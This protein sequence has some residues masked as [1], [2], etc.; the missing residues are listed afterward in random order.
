MKL[1]PDFF[2]KRS[3]ITLDCFTYINSV[4]EWAPIDYGNR[5][6]PEWFKKIPNQTEFGNSTIKI[7]PGIIDFY[8]KGIVIPS[9]FEANIIIK[10]LDEEDYNGKSFLAESS[11][12]SFVQFIDHPPS[13]FFGFSNPNGRN[14]KIVSPW[15]FKCKEDIKFVW[16]QPTWNFTNILQE[17]TI[18]PGVVDFKYQHETHINCLFFIKESR[19]FINIK[20]FMPLAMLHPITEKN[21]LIKRHVVSLDEYQI[22]RG[23][24]NFILAGGADGKP[25]YP[26]TKKLVKE[27]DENLKKCPFHYD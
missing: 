10:S 18:L 22:V 16:T 2:I 21:V 13:Q 11:N 19:R 6:L 27:H 25:K 20:P 14:I 15:M 8:K 1:F 5:Y 24:G 4:D 17:L 12:P 23:I 3:T 26:L 9:W 7:C